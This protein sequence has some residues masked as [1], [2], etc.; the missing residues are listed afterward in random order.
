[1][2]NR[3]P[4]ILYMFYDRANYCAGPRINALRILPEL[5]DRGY[6]T[7]A[8]I[9]YRGACP[10]QTF[11]ETRGVQVRAL[12]WPK[13]VEDQCQKIG[14]VV[15]EVSPDVFI[16][17][18]SVSGCYVARFVR[19]A[20]RPTIAGHLSDD[21]FNWGMAE[22]FC[23]MGDAWAVSG[24]FCM[25]RELAEKVRSWE[26]RRS[27]VVEIA[28][29]V[30]IPACTASPAGN[31]RF[32]YSGRFDTEQKRILEL[33]DSLIAA[34]ERYPDAT[35]K[36]I[37]DG[38]QRD[39]IVRRIKT[40]GLDSRITLTGYVAPESL[41]SEL[42]SENILV[43]LSDYE[44]IPGAVMDGMACGLIPLCLDIPGGLSE[45][46]RHEQTGLL[47]GDRESSFHSAVDRLASDL[48]LRN[49]LAAQ[50][51][52]HVE[53]RFSLSVTVDR[54]ERLIQQLIEKPG[55][56]KEIRIPRSMPLPEP[57]PAFGRQDLRI[58]RNERPFRGLR[59][60]ARRVTRWVQKRAI[61]GN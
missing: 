27:E 33:L 42:L 47:V 37:G 4:K 17:N 31:L 32:V 23:G 52:R 16:P 48:S 36:L 28:H 13:F 14:R 29:G 59:T 40:C 30:P 7:T 53:Q 51:R 58:P 54:W 24:I 10:S 49:R 19:E 2:I 3:R 35:A 38:P 41:H 55:G 8:L 45:L 15:A 20:G 43:L 46:V 61:G 6:E 50:A 44:G 56:R 18:I 12:A 25:G 22:R 60:A 26:P 9:G 11:L 5:V 39:E 57:Y 1:M 21:R 34:L